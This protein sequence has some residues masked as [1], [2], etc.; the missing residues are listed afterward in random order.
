MSESWLVESI[1][2]S[3]VTIEGYNIIRDVYEK[4]RKHGACLYIKNNLKCVEIDVNCLSVAAVHLL[5]HDLWVMAVYHPPSYT[6]AENL[7][8]I[9]V[10][11]TFCEGREVVV[12]G[13]FNLPSVKWSA[14]VI[15]HG[16]SQ[17]DQVFVDC[18]VASG[19]L[20]WVKEPTFVT[21]VNILDVFFTSEDDWVGDVDVLAPFPGS[22]H[23]P[24]QCEYL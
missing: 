19:L 16:V 5:D 21:S 22:G 13:D 3:F 17:N 1:Q 6:V 18:C 8:L 7:M 20:Q 10:I 24:V 2:S 12:L 15:F 9:E 23:S 14:D 4:I 11:T